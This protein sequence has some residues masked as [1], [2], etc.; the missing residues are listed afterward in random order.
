MEELQQNIRISRPMIAGILL[1]LAG[2]IGL[3]SWAP[4][5]MGDES[6]INF[7][8]ENNTGFT[9]E[10]IRNA[11][12]TCGAI[13][14]VLSIFVILGGILSFKSKNWK[15]TI[16]FSVL[17]LLIIGYY[18]LSSIFCVLAILMLLISKKEFQ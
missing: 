18:L 4:F 11:F 13:G 10:Q 5:F 2:I 17:G 3:I 6:L 8:L 16:L 7:V 1:I 15:I 9:E 12:M 14:I